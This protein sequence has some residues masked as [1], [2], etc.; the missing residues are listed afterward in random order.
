MNLVKKMGGRRQVD[1][2]FAE[3]QGI[4]AVDVE[5]NLFDDALLQLE[6]E[7]FE[8]PF[9][10]GSEFD[11]LD[12]NLNQDKPNLCLIFSKETSPSFSASSMPFFSFKAN[13]G[14]TGK[15]A[16]MASISQPTGL[17]NRYFFD[18][19]SASNFSSKTQSRSHNEYVS[20]TKYSGEPSLPATTAAL[21]SLMFNPAFLS[22]LG[23]AANSFNDS[24]LTSF[25]DVNLTTDF[26]FMIFPPCWLEYNTLIFNLSRLF[27]FAE[28]KAA[29]VPLVSDII[30]GRI[31]SIEFIGYEQ[32]YD[33][34]VEG[35]HNFAAGHWVEKTQPPSR[36][37]LASSPAPRPHLV[38]GGIIARNTYISSNLGIGTTNPSE[39][40]EAAE[41]GKKSF[42]DNIVRT[43]D[44]SLYDIR[45][46]IINNPANW[47]SDEHNVKNC[48]GVTAPILQRRPSGAS[49][50]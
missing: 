39:R 25:L 24:N 28:A 14:L 35:T 37:Q 48:S 36:I 47:D 38:F 42:H 49:L 34:E 44:K 40:L 8:F 7:F 16:S 5:F 50:H 21:K 11:L 26:D 3:M 13:L 19:T 12:H 20:K 23:I 46:Y 45:K 1:Q 32:V 17:W 33:I 43:S 4:S 27:S 30:W 6:G 29:E 2:R 9:S 31:V 18:D 41:T 10:T 22:S 15:R